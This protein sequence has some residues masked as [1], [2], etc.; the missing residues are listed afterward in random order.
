MKK[1]SNS[2]ISSAVLLLAVLL[3]LKGSEVLQSRVSIDFSTPLLAVA[4]SEPEVIHQTQRI[5]LAPAIAGE[6]A[7]FRLSEGSLPAGTISFTVDGSGAEVYLMATSSPAPIV[8]TLV[9]DEGELVGPF[10]LSDTEKKVLGPLNNTFETYEVVYDLVDEE[11]IGIE[12]R[13]VSFSLR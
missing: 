6:R 4:L 7:E 1:T 9:D 11:D 5:I 12:N 3:P 13:S 2:V 10:Y 8:I